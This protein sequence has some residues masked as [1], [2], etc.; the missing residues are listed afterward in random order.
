MILFD[1]EKKTVFVADAGK[2]L[3]VRLAKLLANQRPSS[4]SGTPGADK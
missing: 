2:T 3:Q 1:F 4:A